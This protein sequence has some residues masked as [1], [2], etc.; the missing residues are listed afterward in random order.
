MPPHSNDFVPKGLLVLPSSA[1]R[2][3]PCRNTNNYSKDGR[4]VRYET[5]YAENELIISEQMSNTSRATLRPPLTLTLHRYN[6]EKLTRL[7]GRVEGA[8]ADT[9][10][11]HKVKAAENFMVDRAICDMA[12][13]DAECYFLSCDDL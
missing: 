2:A 4:K 12:L 8:K 7:A 6:F 10:A 1:K 11:M 5:D 13:Y 9:E 3:L